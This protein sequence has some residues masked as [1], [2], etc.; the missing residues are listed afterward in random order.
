MFQLPE[1]TH[2]QKKAAYIGLASSVAV[3]SLFFTLSQGS[4]SAADPAVAIPAVSTN[5]AAPTIA[6]TIVVDV[7]GKVLHP[8]VYTLPQGSRAIDAI[9]AA[10][11]KLAGVALTDINLAH[12]LTDGEQIIVGTP[13]I[14]VKSKSAT[15]NHITKSATAAVNI[16]TA[17][18]TQLQT[19]IGVGPATA[20]KVIAY[21]KKNGPFKNLDA[22]KT[23]S[24]MGKS[25]F[26]AIKAQLRM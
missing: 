7:A 9:K 10:G 24:G 14:V 22:F 13:P 25:K 19:L 12:I 16:N 6:P 15:S 21:R 3:A 23:A 4:I 17:T 26:E 2:I 8:D 5:S 1:F 20:Q 18:E 11:G